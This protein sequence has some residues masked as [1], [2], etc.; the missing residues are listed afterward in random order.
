MSRYTRADFNVAGLE[1]Q[2]CD[3]FPF[4]GG[5]FEPE[6]EDSYWFPCQYHEGYIDGFDAQ[7]SNQTCEHD[8]GPWPDESYK[9]CSYKEYDYTYCPK[10]GS[11]L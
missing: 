3:G 8:D 7:R 6:T 9:P 1:P 5:P 10:C 4:N 2:E 11:K